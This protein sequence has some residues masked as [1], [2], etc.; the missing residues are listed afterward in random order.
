MAGEPICQGYG[1]RYDFGTP[2]HDASVHLR[3]KVLRIPLGLAFTVED[4]ASEWTHWHLGWLNRHGELVACMVLVPLGQES[5]KMRQ[6][7]VMPVLQGQGYGRCLVAFGE[8]LARNAG[9]RTMRLNARQ[10]AVPFYLR[11]GYTVCSEQFVEVG[12]PHF[13]MVKEL[14]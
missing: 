13:Q 2:L 9:M 14:G 7:A 3:E 10:E 1:C 4:F 6:V 5:V 11:L 8:S 12:I